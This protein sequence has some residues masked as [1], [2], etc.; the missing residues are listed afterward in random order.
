M[1]GAGTSGEAL[2]NYTQAFT[3]LAFLSAV[4]NLDRVPGTR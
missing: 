1:K 4:F 3:H 2:G